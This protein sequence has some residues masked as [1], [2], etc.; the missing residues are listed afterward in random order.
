MARL[1]NSRIVENNTDQSG[2]LAGGAEDKCRKMSLQNR[3]DGWDGSR[4]SQQAFIDPELCL[5]YL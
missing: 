4:R 3:E 2:G 5:G 1:E